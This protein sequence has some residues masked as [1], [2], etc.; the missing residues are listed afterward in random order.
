MNATA[1]KLIL[2]LTPSYSP[3]RVLDAEGNLL[4]V[5]GHAELL[6][7]GVVV[8]EQY[9]PVLGE[10]AGV[11]PFAPRSREQGVRKQTAPKVAECHPMRA[12]YARSLCHHCYGRKRRAAE[13]VATVSA[14]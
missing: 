6:A 13:A 12:H 1:A 5:I 11:F 7:R 9:A 2:A 3:V 4:R 8:P 10:K 14:A